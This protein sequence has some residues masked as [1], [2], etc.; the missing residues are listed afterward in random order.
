MWQQDLRADAK[1]RKCATVVGNVLGNYHPHGDASVYDALV[2][3]AQAFSLR[4]PLVDG[5]G[6]FG[7]LDGD[8]AAAYRYTECRLARLADQLLIELEQDTVAMRPNYDG[9]KAEPVVL[10][11]RIPNLL[12]NGATGIA[13]GMATNIP[14]HNLGEVCDGAGQ[15]ARQRRADD[16][17]T[18]ASYDQGP[19]LPHRRRRSSTRPTSCR[20]STGPAA[21]RCGC[22]ATWEAGAGR[23]R[24]EDRHV[25]SIPYAVDKCDARRRASATSSSAASCR[26]CSTCATCRPTTSASSSS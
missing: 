8:C 25:T 23:A 15:A 24:L 20:R 5:S 3:M 22:A 7:S 16:A 12:I 19:G 13:V 2:R 1:H 4:Y 17:R 11:A 6:N 14:P 10:P 21:A 9:T 26:R 18:C